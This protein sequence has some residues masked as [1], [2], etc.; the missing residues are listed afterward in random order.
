M[1][2]TL[3]LVAML[4]TSALCTKSEDKMIQNHLAELAEMDSTFKSDSDSFSDIC[5]G[6]AG[7]GD[8]STV[9]DND[10][11]TNTNGHVVTD[12]THTDGVHA[13]VH[14]HHEY[15]EAAGATTHVDADFGSD[16][17]FSTGEATHHVVY[18][19]PVGHATSHSESHE[20][21]ESST[22]VN[23]HTEHDVDHTDTIDGVVHH[24]HHHDHTPVAV[25]AVDVGAGDAGC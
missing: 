22:T 4:L 13:P 15:T 9:T 2:V 5:G 16:A 20:V 17:D 8:T 21:S 25:T 23:G 24:T 7:A 11:Y 12:H 14:T 3:A 1:K 10:V 18:H 6:G 19:E